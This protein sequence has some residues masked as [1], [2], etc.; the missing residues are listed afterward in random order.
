M[1]QDDSYRKL[2]DSERKLL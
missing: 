2:D 1:K